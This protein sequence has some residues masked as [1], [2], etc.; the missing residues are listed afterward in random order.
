[1]NANEIKELLGAFGAGDYIKILHMI[2]MNI[3]PSELEE[4]LSNNSTLVLKTVMEKIE[5]GDAE[6]FCSQI[7]KYPYECFQLLDYTNRY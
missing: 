4:F 6:Y 5:K 3:D 7:S 2:N 1:M